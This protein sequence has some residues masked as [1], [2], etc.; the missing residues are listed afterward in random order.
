MLLALRGEGYG[1]ETPAEDEALFAGAT[2]EGALLIAIS[3]HLSLRP[4]LGVLVPFSRPTF[5]IHDVGP[6]H[7]PSAAA[8]RASLGFEVSF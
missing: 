3:P 6:I 1:V 8:A 5:A 2:A 4:A 7:R